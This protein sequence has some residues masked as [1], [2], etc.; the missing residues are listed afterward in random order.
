MFAKIMA[1]VMA[2]ILITTIGLSA[3]WWVT[4]RDR[5]IETRLDHLISEAE[6][7]AN[8]AALLPG[9]MMDDDW[10]GLP[11]RIAL[12]QKIE[13]V[14]SDFGAFTAV[15][16]SSGG[17]LATTRTRYSE[18]P[19]FRESLNQDEITDALKRIMK[20]ETIR[21]R[22]DSGEASTFTVGVPFRKMGQ[23]AE[24]AVFIQTQAQRIESGLKEL[25]VKIVAIAAGI[26]VLAGV[27]LFLSVRT[28]LKPLKQLTDAAVAV[29]DGD[30]TVQVEENRGGKK[31]REL[32][33]AFNTMTRKLRGVEENRREFV[34]NVSHELRTP[35]TSIRGFAEGMADGVIPPE[36][37]PKYLQLVADEAG[38]MSNLVDNLLA[39]SRLEREDAQ[40]EWAV[41][42]INEML[43]R[44][45]IRRM[46]DLESKGIEAACE[47]E[48]DPCPVRADSDRIE[49]VV[50]NL[51]DN[52][53]KFTPEGGKIT[54][55]SAVRGKAAEITVWDSGP[56]IPEEDREKVFDRF[57]TVDR[58]HTSG[59]GTGLGLS[60]CKRIMEMHKQ[61]LKL[62]DTEEGTAF[63]FTLETAPDGLTEA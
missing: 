10:M 62:M 24:G 56:A 11:M 1:V 54:L 50:T 18:D 59:K 47:P 48:P 61:T 35:I 8:L 20:G 63:L 25:L 39:L 45:I 28:A 5:Q 26:I 60:I 36:E 40:P 29:T 2:A 43:R 7:I 41:F 53:I 22:S 51:L 32:N 19:E 49:Q 17:M 6:D 57:F 52:A 30:L 55:S 38:R 15:V 21:L 31:I 37:Q 42:D 44:A 23:K 16:D 33:R 27:A 4:L 14:N 58:A 9:N 13:K 34:A 46:D 12:E 3:V